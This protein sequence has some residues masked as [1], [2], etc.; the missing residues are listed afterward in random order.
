[1]IGDGGVILP[2]TPYKSAL[3]KQSDSN[4]LLAA[5][6]IQLAVTRAERKEKRSLAQISGSEK[7]A[8]LEDFCRENPLFKKTCNQIALERKLINIQLLAYI[9]NVPPSSIDDWL[10]DWITLS[11]K[12]DR[13]A[14]IQLISNL[15]VCLGV[16]LLGEGEPIEKQRF[17]VL[18]YKMSGS[19][20]W[21]WEKDCPI[22]SDIKSYYLSFEPLAFLSEARYR[23]IRG[24]ADRDRVNKLLFPRVS[25]AWLLAEAAFCR[26]LFENCMRKD[27]F[28]QCWKVYADVLADLGRFKN[29]W[30]HPTKLPQ[31]ITSLDLIFDKVGRDEAALDDEF[32]EKYFEPYI[33]ALKRWNARTRNGRA[34]AI[35]RYIESVPEER[36]RKREK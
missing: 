14:A 20:L 21:S 17:T 15:P 8:L 25:F 1:M 27:E 9:E 34:I 32:S 33:K 10:S 35:P 26:R 4:E 3:S 19:W 28:Y 36:P 11:N 7:L 31:L 13:L 18:L 12:L 30:R 23:L 24:L 22:P 16:G 2:D 6:A 29:L 5:K